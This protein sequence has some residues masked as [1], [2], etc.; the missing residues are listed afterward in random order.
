MVSNHWCLNLSTQR[1]S[2]AHSSTQ[3]QSCIRSSQEVCDILYDGPISWGPLLRATESHLPHRSGHGGHI[4]HPITSSFMMQLALM[5]TM[6][7][8]ITAAILKVS[9]GTS[10]AFSGDGSLCR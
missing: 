6:E 10:Q 1:W 5:I 4:G 7:G 2:S 9:G 8:S 3:R